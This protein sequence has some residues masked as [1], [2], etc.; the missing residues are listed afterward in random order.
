ME[1]CGWGADTASGGPFVQ[2]ALAVATPQRPAPRLDRLDGGRACRLCDGCSNGGATAPPPRETKRNGRR[3]RAAKR[4]EGAKKSGA[5][6][7][8]WLPAS[9]PFG[10]LLVPPSWPYMA[11][12]QWL[13]QS[14]PYAARPLWLPRSWSYVEWPATARASMGPGN[15]DGG[16][17]GCG[18]Q[19]AGRGPCVIR[20]MSSSTYPW[21]S[22]WGRSA[23]PHLRGQW[24]RWK[25]KR[26]GGALY[27][28]C[29]C[30]HSMADGRTRR[31]AAGWTA[32]SCPAVAA[33][34]MG[35]S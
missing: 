15:G 8:L 18:G 5:R 19:A 1:W 22:G 28:G 30:C 4:W 35:T 26:R 14:W 20:M 12:P 13:P 25:M 21:P 9:S 2:M 3:R 33:V 16:V 32:S 11:W 17:K 29:G 23:S 27:E 31:T 6:G 34:G 10:F 7:C 24:G